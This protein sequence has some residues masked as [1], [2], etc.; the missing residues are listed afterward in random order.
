ML[1]Q[2]LLIL[3]CSE[4]EGKIKDILRRE[5]AQITQGSVRG[6]V[7]ACIDTVFRGPR[8][9]DLAGLL[10]KF[11]PSCKA[12]FTALLKEHP[13]AETFYGNI[14]TN[15]HSV[16]HAEGST[17][18]FREVRQYYEAGHVVLDFFDEALASAA[19]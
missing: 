14:I 9:T 19:E 15:R 8:V 6:F 10:G 12:R 17:A 18:S 1:T 7:G 4:F 13:Q 2:Y 5:C 11:G 3:M 16:A